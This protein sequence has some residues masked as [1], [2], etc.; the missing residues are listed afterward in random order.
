ME[1]KAKEIAG[2]ID[3]PDYVRHHKPSINMAGG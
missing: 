2:L 3:N 1:E